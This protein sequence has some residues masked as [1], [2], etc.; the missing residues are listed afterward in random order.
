[1]PREFFS[2]GKILVELNPKTHF[3]VW[4]FNAGEKASG[5]EG[6]GVV[7][8]WASS[9]WSIV[10]VKRNLIPH[11]AIVAL[12]VRHRRS[13]SAALIFRKRLSRKTPIL[14]RPS[15]LDARHAV[16]P[17]RS[18]AMAEIDPLDEWR[19]EFSSG[20]RNIH[21]EERL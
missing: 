7:W 6:S 10:A 9:R 5:A 11:K 1:L 3:Q 19:Q 21:I 8:S 20:R 2:R 15:H 14:C 12:T 13:V 4:I 18:H 16:S 17:A